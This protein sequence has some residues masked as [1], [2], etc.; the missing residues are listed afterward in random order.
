[1]ET[2]PGR[3]TYQISD[4]GPLRP[5]PDLLTNEALLLEG[6]NSGSEEKVRQA[7]DAG[8]NC[9]L[10]LSTDLPPIDDDISVSFTATRLQI[11]KTFLD[12]AIENGDA[13]IARL[14][15]RRGAKFEVFDYTVD[16]E[17]SR[18]VALPGAAGD[19]TYCWD[20]VL[21]YGA[22]T[23]NLE[24]CDLALEQGANVNCIGPNRITPLIIASENGF[25]DIVRVLLSK[26]ADTSLAGCSAKEPRSG[27]QKTALM[28]AEAGNHAEVARMLRAAGR[29]SLADLVKGLFR[30]SRP[31][32]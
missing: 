9:A 30:P 2:P 11:V 23:Q 15:V 16:R 19:K 25:Q 8:A 4:I 7:L 32:G 29:N 17:G 20:N 31:A 5:R 26:K 24:L 14:L 13:D 10:T 1:M 21:I 18:H 6:L 28:W 22:T 3:S 27:E 12:V